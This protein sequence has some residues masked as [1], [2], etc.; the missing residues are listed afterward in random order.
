VYK[1]YRSAKIGT[2]DAN[3]RNVEISAGETHYSIGG[4]VDWGG[5]DFNPFAEPKKK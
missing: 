1:E 3:W 2:W 4:S 5:F